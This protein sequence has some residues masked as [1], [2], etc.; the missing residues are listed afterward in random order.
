VVLYNGE[1]KWTHSTAQGIKDVYIDA[2]GNIWGIHPEGV[3]KF[4]NLYV[5]F[6]D[7]V[8]DKFDSKSKIFIFEHQKKLFLLAGILMWE[9]DSENE[10]FIKLGPESINLPVYTSNTIQ[11]EK[12]NLYMFSKKSIYRVNLVNGHIDSIM[13]QNPNYFI[14]LNENDLF[15]SNSKFETYKISFSNPSQEKI[16]PILS[17]NKKE[18][19]HFLIFNA[20]RVNDHCFI[21]ATNL[22]V[23]E[24]DHTTKTFIKP[25]FNIN[26][27]PVYSTQSVKYLEKSNNDEIY[28]TSTDGI[29][30]FRRT[31][32]GFNYIKS[33]IDEDQELQDVD[34]RGFTE[35]SQGNIWIAT[36]NGLLQINYKT[37][38]IQN[39]VQS[40]F[41]QNQF[42]PSVRFVLFHQGKLWVG[43]G[44]KGIWVYNSRLKKLDRPLLFPVNKSAKDV[45][46]TFQN[47]FIWKIL[48]LKDGNLFVAGGN[49]CYTIDV[50]SNNIIRHDKDLLPGI[51]RT[52][53]QDSIG[54]IWHGTSAGITVLDHGY[55]PILTIRDT[56]FPSSVSSLVEWKKNHNFIGSKG[57]YEC[58]IGDDNAV[59]FQKINVFP[60]DVQIFC[61]TKSREG[62]IWIG[63]YDGLYY[64]NPSRKIIRKFS[65]SDN[66]Q[67]HSFNSNGL[68]VSSKGKI[69]AGGKGGINFFFPSD[70]L[71]ESKH[72]SP[73]IS[74]FQKGVDDSTF[75]LKS[76]PL[77]IEH[78]EKV[79]TAAISVSN[80][81]PDD[82]LYYRY[83][84]LPEE[85]WYYNG[86][87]H[88]IRLH[89][90][91][92]GQY[93]IQVSASRDGLNWFDGHSPYHFE[94]LK[95]WWKKGWFYVLLGTVLT[96][97][98]LQLRRY[99]N[100][101]RRKEKIEETIRFF[102]LETFQ[103]SSL[104][105]IC[106]TIARNCLAGFDL[107]DCIIY[108][109]DKERN[110]LIQKAAIGSKS[111]FN[112]EIVD[113]IEIPLG[114]GITGSAA[115][116][117]KT[118]WVKDTSKDARYIQDDKV[119]MSELAVPIINQGEVIG[120]IDSEHSKKNFFTLEHVEALNTIANLTSSKILQAIVW[121]EKIKAEEKLNEI[122]SKLLE[123]KFMNLRLQ[124]NP[125][126]LFNALSSIQHLIISNQ[127]KEGYKYLT[128]FSVFLRSILQYAD[129]SAITLDEEIKMLEMYIKL[130][131]L[132][133]D[134]IF[135]YTL[136]IDDSVDIEDTLIPPLL[137]QPLVENAIWHG[138]MQKDSDRFLKISFIEIDDDFYV[139][140]V[141]D[142][143]IGIQAA[144]QKSKGDLEKRTHES[145]S[146][147]LIKERLQIIAQKTGKEASLSFSDMDSLN[148]IPG[149]KAVIKIPYFTIDQI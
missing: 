13:F 106:W 22:G 27:S 64:Y 118:Q 119:R 72:L 39:S 133:S 83:K 26:G 146:L 121:N 1:T 127:A 97:S 139:C 45:I 103:Q 3:K 95:P 55:K 9:Y 61:M 130:E 6:M 136:S 140:E 88:V 94:I 129:K 20:T 123:T 19:F 93:S 35:D 111:T 141:Q 43:T 87:N 63:A 57:L 84:L 67:G 73:F 4:K 81:Y 114:Q 10:L 47:E 54:R 11:I 143:G 66:V 148:E 41:D 24:Y 125:H 7:V 68:Y 37:G 99:I 115:L 8:V 113:P 86:N 60:E 62:N 42:Y 120:V 30:Y 104:D 110:M 21:M 65:T 70:V 78:T 44:G 50:E 122:N 102:S 79:I 100:H 149:T 126:F 134:K 138:L 80:F 105:N 132:G 18:V 89:G 38:K 32:K 31:S 90:L 112:N 34:A 51:S 46:T 92:S 56:I 116:S 144:S 16:L 2:S 117:G 147:F 135:D 85:K 15:V 91:P 25:D 58:F 12:S 137:L 49:F 29:V 82:R 101:Q 14:P 108:I 128:I 77:L 124:M 131:S 28:M 76:S 107:E 98:F 53:I 5:G 96:I 48:P 109:L 142:N 59:E 40:T 71:Y 69:Y 75:Y 145:K 17:N 52:A 36:I 23:L 74:V 33:Y